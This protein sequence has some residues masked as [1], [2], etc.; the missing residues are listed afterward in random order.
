MLGFM[1]IYS[2]EVCWFVQGLGCDWWYEVNIPEHVR[3]TVDKVAGLTNNRLRIRWTGVS[4]VFMKILIVSLIRPNKDYCSCVFN[5]GY[6]GDH[7]LVESVQKRWSGCVEGLAGMDYIGRQQVLD[8]FTPRNKRLRCDLIKIRKLFRS[9]GLYI[10]ALFNV[11]VARATSSHKI[12]D[13]GTKLPFIFKITFFTCDIY[14]FVERLSC[15]WG[16]VVVVVI[17]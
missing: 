6:L 17:V 10:R 15:R 13:F 8:L 1:L 14:Q 5:V 7:W 11:N 3:T 4:Y 16:W 12:S 9:G 2:V